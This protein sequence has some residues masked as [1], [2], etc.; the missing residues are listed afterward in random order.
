MILDQN[1]IR[2]K[3]C[4]KPLQAWNNKWINRLNVSVVVR[5]DMCRKNCK[6]NKNIPNKP[7]HT[8]EKTLGL[9]T[10]CNKRNHWANQCRSKFHKNG[11]PLSGNWK[12]GPTQGPSNNSSSQQTWIAVPFVYPASEQQP[13][14]AL[15]NH[16]PRLPTSFLQ[17]P[18]DQH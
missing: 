15:P 9:C 5:K 1:P 14:P 18:G 12:K 7:T 10:R 16:T 11:S 4:F 2:C 3:Y 6:T 8:N 13:C 17:H